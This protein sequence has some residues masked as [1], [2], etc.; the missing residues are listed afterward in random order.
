MSAY[1]NL[2]AAD[3]G[4]MRVEVMLAGWKN[5]HPGEQYLRKYID[6][7]EH[8]ANKCYVARS[9]RIE[10]WYENP[11]NLPGRYYLQAIEELFKAIRAPQRD[12]VGLGRKLSLK[13]IQ[14]PLCLLAGEAY[15]TQPILKNAA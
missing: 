4:R 7:Y 12:F 1:R 13:E 6:L 2:V 5:M 14:V 9:E 10:R 8:I 3:G 15:F 11:I